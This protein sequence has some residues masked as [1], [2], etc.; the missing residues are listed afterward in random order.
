MT[1]LHVVKEVK[2]VDTGFSGQNLGL[3]RG[4]PQYTETLMPF[5]AEKI[6][7]IQQ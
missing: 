5:E 3:H 7:N 6:V 1:F 4:L 2:E